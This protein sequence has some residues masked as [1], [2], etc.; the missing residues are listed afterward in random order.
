MKPEHQRALAAAEARRAELIEQTSAKLALLNQEK[1]LIEQWARRKAEEATLA[2]SEFLANMSHEIRTPMNAIIGMAHLALRTDLSPRQR[3]YLDKIG[4]ASQSLL[5]V[6]NDILDLSKIEAGKLGLETVAFSLDDVLSGLASSTGALAAAKGLIYGFDVPKNVPRQLRGDPL[7]LGQVL[8]NLVSNAIK[9]TA[10]GKVTMSCVLLQHDA[11]RV[12]LRFSVQDSGIGMSPEQTGRLFAPMRTPV[13]NAGVN[14]ASIAAA[15]AFAPAPAPAPAPCGNRLAALADMQG[16]VGL[17]GDLVGSGAQIG[18]T[19]LGLLIARQLVQLMGGEL[20]VQT[21]P[22][23]GAT[24]SFDLNLPLAE[25]Q[26][27]ELHWPQARVLLVTPDPGQQQWLRDALCELP[28]EID[29]VGS[30]EQALFAL[31]GAS[32]NPYRL[33]LA[34]MVLGG[35]SGAELCRRVRNGGHMNNPPASGTAQ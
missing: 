4:R 24:F 33:L 1:I 15:P 3:D 16:Q 34:D 17:T 28:L 31:R 14:G 18:A 23:R 2:K 9:F 8:L 25:A 5:S 21:A 7:R 19:G 26:P 27:L 29:A 22:G 11:N 20:S 12:D 6:I 30:G 10:Q 13:V 32:S 35:L